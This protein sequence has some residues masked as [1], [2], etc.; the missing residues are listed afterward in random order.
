MDLGGITP[1]ASKMPFRFKASLRLS[2]PS[3]DPNEIS[4]SLGLTPQRAW[5]ADQERST[6]QGT[7]L[8]G[9]YEFTYW[10]TSIA[11]SETSSLTDELEPWIDYLSDRA[12]FLEHFSES[13]GEIEFF[14]GW[15]TTEVSG[16]E[17]FDWQFL[18]RLAQLKINLAFD[19]YQ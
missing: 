7:P 17:T 9:V 1:T 14:V 11:E 15:F 6:P 4:S 12:S 10:S 8:Q 13:G 2:H 3:M 18:K 16:G 5:R 19:V